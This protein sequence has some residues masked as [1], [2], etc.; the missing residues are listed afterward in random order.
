MPSELQRMNTLTPSGLGL[1]LTNCLAA[2]LPV[3]GTICSSMLFLSH[4]GSIRH[5]SL[6]ATSSGLTFQSLSFGERGD[7]NS[8]MC[9]AERSLKNRFTLVASE[10]TGIWVA[11]CQYNLIL[12]NFSVPIIIR[13]PRNVLISSGVVTRMAPVV[14]S[15]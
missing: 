1:F 3:K 10:T 8:P 4:G 9:R 13:I 6:I 15:T 12:G 14:S 7:D 2:T 5:R 11:G